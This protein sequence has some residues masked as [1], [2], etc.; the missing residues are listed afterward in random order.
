M[1]T[2]VDALTPLEALTRDLRTAARTLSD[3]EARFLVDNYYIMQDDRKRAHN[4]T[5][6]LEGSEEPH[7][8]LQWLA[9]NSRRLEDNIKRALQAYAEGQA[10][11]QWLLSITG[12]GPVI[13]AGLISYIPIEQTPS[14]S[15]LWAYAGLA[16]GQR[17]EKGAKLTYNPSLKVLCWKAGESF[18][19]FQNH[20]R[21]HYGR[22]YAQRKV[23]EQ[24][25][26]SQG[27]YAEQA[28]AALTNKRYGADTE[29]FKWYAQGL[30][31]PAHIHARAK[32]WAVKLFLS[33]FWEVAYTLH[34]GEAPTLRPYVFDILGHSRYIPIPNWEMGE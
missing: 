29:A 16:P 25:R 7:L 8:V 14:A 5:L 28:R 24:E 1:T 23:V 10:V 3:R 31:P 30:L 22:Y 15:A 11:G 21:D 27:L 13:S 4:Q 33:H 6:M 34:Y 20:L 17:R 19:K 18:V 9:E 12:I 32:R 26:N 2:I